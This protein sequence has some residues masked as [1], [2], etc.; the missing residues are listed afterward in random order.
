ML[1]R[2][3][4]LVYATPDLNSGMA[5]IEM[6]LGIRATFGGQ[7]PG[8]GTRNAL[9]ALGPAT[10]L[11]IIA[12]DPEQP[13]PETPRPF[14]IDRLKESRLVAWAA[15]AR[16]LE[17]L[18]RE[19]ASQGVQLGDVTPGS[20]RRSDGVVLSWRSTSPLT[21]GGDGIVPFFID[22][23]Q[24]P[25]PAR[26]AAEGASLVDFR[27]EHPDTARV[28]DI[29]RRLG[30]DLPVKHGPSPALIAVVDGPRGRVELR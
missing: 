3:D 30:L 2:V 6:L 4:H 13:S 8:R 24:S 18:R 11:E 20:R 28:Q 22:W 10:Y 5:E 14:G 1:H 15:N 25:H 16:D 21:A 12:P 29:L 26:T 23:R 7:H 27:A 17:H 9:I 19:A